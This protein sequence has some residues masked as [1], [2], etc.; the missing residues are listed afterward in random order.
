MN[1]APD[2]DSNGSGGIVTA[3]LY[4]SLSS[5]LP[6]YFSCAK[7]FVKLDSS[8][9]FARFQRHQFFKMLAKLKRAKRWPGKC[10]GF[11]VASNEHTL[12]LLRYRSIFLVLQV[13]LK[14]ILGSRAVAF[15]FLNK[16]TINLTWSGWLSSRARPER[17][18]VSTVVS[19]NQRFFPRLTDRWPRPISSQI[20]S[21]DLL[22]A[23]SS[24]ILTFS[25]VG[26]FFQLWRETFYS[27]CFLVNFVTTAPL[28]IQADHWR[29]RSIKSDGKVHRR[30]HDHLS[31]CFRMQPPSP[32]ILRVSLLQSHFRSNKLPFLFRKSHP[33]TQ[34]I[35]KANK[36]LKKHKQSNCNFVIWNYHIFTRE[37]G[38]T[39]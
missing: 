29:R 33:F 31:Y 1:L 34:F 12:F 14:A 6:A 18:R 17:G 15:E 7:L 8:E 26:Q 9:N 23:F 11:I 10:V 30:L 20:L 35:L 5:A 19:S 3:C 13:N 4:R 16:K 32:P 2:I 27:S 24:K 38:N 21:T 39:S 36:S 22:L 28:I 37:W 25:E